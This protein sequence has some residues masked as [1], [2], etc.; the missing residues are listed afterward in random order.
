MSLT[1][2]VAQYVMSEVFAAID[3][4]LSEEYTK[5]Q[6]LMPKSGAFI[7]VQE[8]NLTLNYPTQQ[9]ESHRVV[10]LDRAEGGT[11]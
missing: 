9:A 11:S 5:I 4:R 3:H 7:L 1:D 10:R 6:A 2:S 8:P